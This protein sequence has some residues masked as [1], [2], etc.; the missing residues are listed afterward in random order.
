MLK[1]HLPSHRGTQSKL[2]EYVW[3][4]TTL[5]GSP[6]IFTSLL[7]M[8]CVEETKNYE[9]GPSN[10]QVVGVKRAGKGQDNGTTAL[11]GTQRNT[12]YICPPMLT[13]ATHSSQALTVREHQWH[14]N[15]A[16]SDYCTEENEP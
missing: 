11:G 7:I 9:D 14:R 3:P 4:Y 1:A 6:A 8:R 5:E 15:S 12:S 10:N 2:Y 13:C 16:N